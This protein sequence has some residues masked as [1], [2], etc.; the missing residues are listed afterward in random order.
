MPYPKLVSTILNIGVAPHHSID[1]KQSI[2]FVNGTAFCFAC[3]ALIMASTLFF[4]A[5]T[6]PLLPSLGLV[7]SVCLISTLYWNH[8]QKFLLGQITI[9]YLFPL[10]IFLSQFI[11]KHQT[12]ISELKEF[13]YYIP[14]LF[15]AWLVFIALHIYPKNTT[16]SIFN[17]LFIFGLLLLQAPLNYFTGVGFVKTGNTIQTYV[18]FIGLLL[19]MAGTYVAMFLMQTK[20]IHHQG[21]HH[22]AININLNKL[23]KQ[24][25]QELEKSHEFLKQLHLISITELPPRARIQH[26]LDECKKFLTMDLSILSRIDPQQ[27]YTIQQVTTNPLNIK[28][29]DT[30]PLEDTICNLIAFK[31]HQYQNP[32]VITIEQN[33]VYYDRPTFQQMPLKAYIGIAILVEGKLYGTISMSSTTTPRKNFTP[34]EVALF[35]QAAQAISNELTRQMAQQKLKQ[36]EQEYYTLTQAIPVG[37]FKNDPKGLCTF[38]NQKMSDITSLSFKQCLGSGWTQSLHPE[39]ASKVSDAWINFVQHNQPYNLQFRLT[40]PQQEVKWVYAQAVKQYDTQGQTTGIV[41]SVSDI[42]D[43]VRSK[44]ESERLI[45]IAKNIDDM[46]IITNPKGQVEW[47]NESFTRHTGYPLAEIVGKKPGQLLQGEHTQPEQV[48]RLREAVQQKKTTQLEIINYTKHGRMFW[49]DLRIQPV[50]NEKGVLTNYISIEK[51]ITERKAFIQKLETSE[52]RFRNYVNNAPFGVFLLDNHGQILEVNQA[53]CKITG[54]QETELLTF[55]FAQI[56]EKQYQKNL[57]ERLKLIPQTRFHN[58][59]YTFIKKDGDRAYWRVNVSLIDEQNLLVF[60]ENITTRLMIIMKLRSNEKKF[61]SYVN[62]APHGVFVTDNQGYYQEVNRAATVITGYSRSELLRMNV[63]DL[64]DSSVQQKAAQAFTQPDEVGSVE[65]PF[66]KQDETKAYWSISTAKISNDRVIGFAQDITHRKM[67]EKKLTEMSQEIELQNNKLQLAINSGNFIVWELDLLWRNMKF[68]S[69]DKENIFFERD[70]LVSNLDDFLQTIH[71]TQRETLVR[72]I[73]EHIAGNT[74]FIGHDF[75]VETRDKQ[76]KW[77][78]CQGKVIQWNDRGNPVTAYGVMQDISLKKNTELLLFQGQEKERKR[79][80]REIHDSIGQMLFASRFLINKYL[81]QPIDNIKLE[82]IDNLMVDILKETRYIINNLGVSVFDNDN[83][84]L[85][86]QSLI[87]KMQDA[88]NCAISFTW[89]GD[90]QIIDP[91]KS[92]HIFRIFQES[93]YN[94][95]KYAQAS[96]V[97]VVVDNQDYFQMGISDDGVGFEI[98]DII[99]KESFGLS[100]IRHR[101]KTIGAQVQIISRSGQGTLI[102]LWLG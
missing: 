34:G 61:R 32:F 1:Q 71:P 58:L 94:A 3:I 102:V 5:S 40:S 49:L 51:D 25:T 65:L 15:I 26:I 35:C 78:Y 88:A 47:V 57:I 56:H 77:I 23:V 41:S 76:W 18:L 11:V 95:I 36:R 98:N 39:D 63:V 62:N 69:P 44:Q 24:R 99:Q 10:F 53:A 4:T 87:K 29:G 89:N 13:M 66:V 17:A 67:Q 50:F 59:D 48:A 90:H 33:N 72:K 28:P 14:S 38:V 16:A 96:E 43:I 81:A 6:A 52:E 20:E 42:T 55:N 22:R 9:G 100:N 2:C 75:Q 84:F 86:F 82:Q 92:T 31:N 68:L 27:T 54:Y 45:L 70:D 74:P 79:I 37:V 80:S 91:S 60:T 30:Y 97:S 83:L 12:P 64:H 46:V 19:V 8:Q 21:I 7:I 93:L 85:A 101:A 73:E